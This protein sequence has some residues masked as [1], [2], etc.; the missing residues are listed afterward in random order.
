VFSTGLQGSR[1]EVSELAA[2]LDTHKQVAQGIGH[3]QR[4]EKERLGAAFPKLQNSG[5]HL[6]PCSG[7]GPPGTV[8]KGGIFNFI[9]KLIL[10]PP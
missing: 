10:P 9:E 4:R 5:F 7:L 8:A 3:S 1:V 2:S 6:Q